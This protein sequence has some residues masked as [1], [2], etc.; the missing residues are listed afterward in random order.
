MNRRH[1]F[2]PR[3]LVLIVLWLALSASAWSGTSITYQGQL[4]SNGQP[5]NGTIDLAFR[6]WTAEIGGTQLGDLQ[7]FVNHPVSNGLFQADLDFSG[8]SMDGSPRFLEVRIEGEWLAPRQPLR[9]APMAL[10][11]LSSGGGGGGESAW[12]VSGSDIHFTGGNV[13]IGTSNPQS[14]LEVV[15]AVTLDG[16]RLRNH[17]STPSVIGGRSSNSIGPNVE[18]AFIGGGGSF[19]AGSEVPNTVTGNFGA[20]AGGLGNTASGFAASIPGGSG[21]LAQGTNSLAAGRQARALHDNSFVWADDNGTFSSTGPN[22]FLVQAEGGV[23][24]GRNNPN[25]F[26]EI[27]APF[28]EESENFEDGA[29]RVLLNGAT[30]FRVLRNGGVGIGGSYNS[31]GVPDRGLRVHGQA[32]FDGLVDIKS[33]VFFRQAIYFLGQ[34][35][36][37]GGHTQL[38]RGD[39]ALTECSSSARYK[40]QIE[41]L[42]GAALDLLEQL[43]PVSYRWKSNGVADIGLVAEEVAEVEPRLVF[44]NSYGEVEGVRYD[45]LTAVLIKAMREERNATVAKLAE[46]DARIEE[47]ETR[48]QDQAVRMESRLLALESLLLGEAP[49][50]A[51]QQAMDPMESQP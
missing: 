14:A 13:G 21:N 44:S 10:Y 4:L 37:V 7:R 27:N 41:D 32:H 50:L 43:R 48:L 31:S 36:T 33:S 18:G 19:I 16:L 3:H 47:L 11:A 20:I 5:H 23:G 40:E 9:A 46:R 34:L 8:V 30:R 15:G 24:F 38:C 42:D 49:A 26:F 35:P 12:T 28:N 51:I 6:V 45:R 1:T 39:Y 17:G 2:S 25:D 29:L 22:Q